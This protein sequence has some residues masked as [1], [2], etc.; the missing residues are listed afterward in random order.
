MKKSVGGSKKVTIFLCLSV[1]LLYACTK[2]PE[3]Y[4]YGADNEIANVEEFAKLNE[5]ISSEIPHLYINIDN[6]EE[7]V[8]K[9][10][11]LNADFSIKGNEKY[12]DISAIKTRIRGRGNSTWGL[13]KKPYR[14]KLD[15][16][17]SILGLAPAKD[18]VLLANYRDYT[19]M[20]NA[21]AMKIGKQ[22]G[23]PFTHDIIP[24][25]VTVNGVYRGNYNL[26]QQVEVH[27][28]RVNVGEGG[29]L[30]ELDSYFDE[31]WQ[32]MSNK[33]KLPVML[34]DPKVQSNSQFEEWV[35]EFNLFDEL[36]YAKKFP[37]NEYSDLLDKQ[38][39]VN[40]L[41]VNM[42]IGNNE[43]NHPKS[44][45]MHKKNGGKYTMGPLWDF[46][47]GFG[48]SEEHKK[49]YFNYVDL[50]VIRTN[51]NRIGS[52]FFRKVLSDPE[53]KTLF[54][55]TWS[56][57]KKN[58]FN[59]LMEFIEYYAASIRDSQK[60]DYGKWKVGNNQHAKNKADLK[61]FLRKRTVVIDNFIKT[62]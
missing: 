2:K 50:S 58:H 59:E 8:V 18:W 35:R 11:Y 48:F 21:V 40:F 41:I 55:K 4:N 14:L 51:D 49:T 45:F 32:F 42:F 30:W 61:T 26:T 36:L 27:E 34:K 52:K 20:T 13:P 57:Y 33:S 1:M 25:D 47:Y 53:I 9:E 60:K 22:L 7:I 6:K 29:V 37:K 24:V 15:K 46:D 62:F 19:F 12:A 54:K 16:S 31:E 3:L 10:K 44:V 28:N 43:I 23:M 56:T 17:A 5:S 38:Q 39:F